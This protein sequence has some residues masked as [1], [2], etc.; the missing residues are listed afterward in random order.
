MFRGVHF[1]R[2]LRLSAF[3]STH[4]CTVMHALR[5]EVVGGAREEVF[6]QSRVLDVYFMHYKHDSGK[7]SICWCPAG[8]G[9]EQ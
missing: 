1:G 5:Q 8:A 2:D 9:T 3:S 4:V 6:E 7:K